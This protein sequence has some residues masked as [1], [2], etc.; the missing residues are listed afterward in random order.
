MLHRNMIANIVSDQAAQTLRAVT[1]ATG[2][3]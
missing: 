3:T 2:E 1:R